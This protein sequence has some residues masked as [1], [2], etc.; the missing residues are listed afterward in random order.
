MFGD[1]QAQY[2]TGMA[3]S[4]SKGFYTSKK[5]AFSGWIKP[6]RLGTQERNRRQKIFGEG[7]VR[8]WYKSTIS[9]GF[10]FHIAFVDELGK[11]TDLPKCTNH[12][13]TALSL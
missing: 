13:Q 11:E 3:L 4:E 10:D 9:V 8:Q 12:R 1:P 5:L 7:V 6:P 2:D